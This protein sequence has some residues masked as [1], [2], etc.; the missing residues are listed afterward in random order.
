MSISEPDSRHEVIL[1]LENARQISSLLSPNERQAVA[2]FLALLQ[3]HY[4]E[5]VLQ[6]ILFGSKARGDSRSWSDVDILTVVDR[7]DWRLSHAISI[8]AADVSLEYDVLI[9]PRVIG[10]ERW[11]RMKERRFSLYQNIAAEGIPLT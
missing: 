3:Q 9:G 7:D 10:Q 6:T 11:E 5:R 1:Y 4:P 2:S 8:L